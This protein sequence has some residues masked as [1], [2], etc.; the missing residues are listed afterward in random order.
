MKVIS[1]SL[2]F[3]YMILIDSVSINF[4]NLIINSQKK[5]TYIA[6]N[7]ENHP[8]SLE[9]QKEYDSYM[10]LY[11]KKDCN[12][13]SGF[14]NEYRN[15]ISFIIN[16]KNNSKLKSEDELIITKDICIEIHFDKNINNLTYFFFKIF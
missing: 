13:S 9:E 6:K 3:F 8:R 1:F 5:R 10:L 7:E 14:K 16:R 2:I 15:N 4:F 12:Y 11:F